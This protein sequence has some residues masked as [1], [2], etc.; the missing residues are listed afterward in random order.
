MTILSRVAVAFLGGLL[1]VRAAPA[2]DSVLDRRQS[3]TA[4]STS[5]INAFTPYTYYA[6][7]AYCAAS[8]TASWSCGAACSAN[9]KFEVVASGGDGDSVQYSACSA[10]SKFEVVASGGDGDSVQYWYVGYDPSLKT[11]IVA[12]QGT[13]PSELLPL[14][15]DA[16]IITENLSSSLFPGISTSIEVHSGFAGA[17]A[18]AATQVLAAVKTA[19]SKGNT[20]S[21]TLTG[22]SLGAAIALLDSVYLPLH[23]PSSTTF[24]TVVYG[25]PRVGNQAFANYVDA[26][27]HLTHINNLKD[28]IPIVPG[29]FLGFVHPSGEVH[30]ESSGEWASCPGQDNTSTSCIV[31]DEPNLLDADLSNHDGPYNGVTMGSGRSR[32]LLRIDSSAVIERVR[33]VRCLKPFLY[34]STRRPHPMMA[35]SQNAPAGPSNIRPPSSFEFTKRKK[36]ADLLIS[37]LTDSIQLI[38]SAQGKVLFCSP[39]VTELL[40]WRDEDLIDRDFVELINSEDCANFKDAYDT[41]LQSRD[42]MLCYIRLRCNAPFSGNYNAPPKEVLFEFKG[43]P[44]FMPG[45]A[46]CKVFFAAAKPYP[47][48]NTAMLNTFLELKMENERLLQR[49]AELHQQAPSLSPS[50]TS[51]TSALTYGNSRPYPITIP[52]SDETSQPYYPRS[53]GAGY[54]NMSMMASPLSSSFGNSTMS[55]Y[56]ALH[57]AHAQVAEDTPDGGN[58]KKKLKKSHPNEQYVCVTCGRTD[59]PEWRKVYFFLP[60]PSGAHYERLLQGPQGPKTLCNACGLRWAKQQRKG[61]D[62]TGGE[63]SMLQLS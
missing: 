41:S 12:H 27:L 22:H 49:R 54:G 53:A 36:Y 47:S 44:H 2:F 29:R 7:A 33:H 51:S 16:D 11:V 58:T 31:G 39:A 23:L 37:E 17:Q 6:S 42:S 26:N 20:Q 14:L 63:P 61:D 4:L 10:N 28:P 62:D 50:I 52:R 8:T 40:G 57:N 3:I 56:G 24:K 46:E 9:S 35:T 60:E 48:R 32:K 45:E 1:A 19:M 25:L 43:H 5:Q 18:D 15:T 55:P 13:D 38:L 21:V 34:S 59:S 30:I